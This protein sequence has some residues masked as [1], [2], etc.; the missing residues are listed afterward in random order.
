[1]NAEFQK[2]IDTL[3]ARMVTLN[4]SPLY[5]RSDS[6]QFPHK[7][8]YVFFEEGQPLYV[9]RS[10]SMKNR[11]QQHSR[12]SSGHNSASF[13]FILAKEI[14]KKSGTDVTQSREGL[15]QDPVFGRIYLTMKERVWKMQIRVVSIEDPIEQT[16]FEV[17]AALELKTPYNEW[18]TH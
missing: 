2:I 1:M 5:A 17:Y 12:P 15:E 14:V 4:N 13:A 18:G 6:R 7:G 16:F 9:G 11:I 10:D 3:P 8:I